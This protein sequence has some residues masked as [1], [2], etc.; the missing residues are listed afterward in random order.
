MVQNLHRDTVPCNWNQGKQDRKLLINAGGQHIIHETLRP[1]EENTWPH[2]YQNVASLTW[3]AEESFNF[4]H[5]RPYC[6]RGFELHLVTSNIRYNEILWRIPYG[7]LNNSLELCHHI[8]TY[9]NIL[10]S[11]SLLPEFIL[12]KVL[13]Q[14]RLCL[15]KRPL[16]CIMFKNTNDRLEVIYSWTYQRKFR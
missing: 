14:S 16:I 7:L 10:I 11:L 4:H 5:Q 8:V 12:E 13:T 1:A 3:K 2:Q 15:R 9:S 6:S